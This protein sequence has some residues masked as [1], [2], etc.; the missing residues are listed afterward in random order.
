MEYDNIWKHD[1]AY[2]S[3]LCLDKKIQG[4]C[5][6]WFYWNQIFKRF[7]IWYILFHWRSPS[8]SYLKIFSTWIEPHNWYLNVTTFPKSLPNHDWKKKTCILL[9]FFQLDSKNRPRYSHI[10]SKLRPSLSII[11]LLGF[12]KALS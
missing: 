5:L 2:P 11:I 3:Y 10:T 8:S 6:I 1:F 9:R 4:S 12:S 7:V